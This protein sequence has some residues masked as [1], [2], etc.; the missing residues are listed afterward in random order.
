MAICTSTP[1]L[2]RVVADSVCASKSALVALSTV[3][4][5]QDRA[6]VGHLHVDAAAM[7][8][9]SMMTLSVWVVSLMAI[10]KLTPLLCCVVADSS[11]QASQL[12]LH[13]APW[14]LCRVGP[15]MAICT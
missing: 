3:G 4:A 5:V 1:L 9:A 6:N 2:C 11:V 12:F 15:V 14:V 7:A 10:C 8:A 13:S